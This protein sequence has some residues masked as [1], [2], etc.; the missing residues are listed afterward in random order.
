MNNKT[1][2][3]TSYRVW[4]S[5]LLGLCLFI[6]A[7]A[8]G[9]AALAFIPALSAFSGANEIVP[10][11]Q[12]APLVGQ[13]INSLVIPG[14]ALM[15][16]VLVPQGLACICMLRKHPRQIDAGIF[17]GVMLIVCQIGELVLIP[18]PLS[19]I[20]LTLGAI[21]IFAGIMCLRVKG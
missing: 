14:F 9:G 6:A 21:Q 10:V 5:I 3:N 19:V 17:A 8:V 18:N 7:G 1:Q 20:Y 11:L 13:Y 12:Q 16:L 4:R 2:S 15:L